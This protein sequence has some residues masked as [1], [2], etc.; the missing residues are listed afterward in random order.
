MEAAGDEA[1]SVENSPRMNRPGEFSSAQKHS[2]F[3]PEIHRN[4]LPKIL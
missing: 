1:G 4:L 2:P 3:T